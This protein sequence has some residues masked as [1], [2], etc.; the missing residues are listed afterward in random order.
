[1][2]QTSSD[3]NGESFYQDKEKRIKSF[4]K[5]LMSNPTINET[6]DNSTD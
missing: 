5:R 3:I 1:M 6:S 4:I 2:I